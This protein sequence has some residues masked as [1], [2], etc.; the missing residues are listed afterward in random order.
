MAIK[1]QKFVIDEA[2]LDLIG[3]EFKFDHAKGLAEWIK[4]SCDAYLRESVPDDM[5][6]IILRLIEDKRGSINCIECIDFVGME[7]RQI[8]DAFKRFFDPLAAKKGAKEAQIKTLGGH[9][10]GGKFYM[11]Q[12]FK[13]SQAITYRNGK[14]NIFGFNSKRQYGFEEDYED[15]SM[16]AQE[17]MKKAKIDNILFP[18]DVKSKLISGEIGFTVVRG[19]NPHKV[20]GTASRDKLVEKLVYHPQARRLI[21]RKPISVVFND[22][23]QPSKL[24]PPKLIPKEGF[25]E[26]IVVPIPDTI[27]FEGK[28]IFFKMQNFDWPGRLVLRTSNDPLRGNLAT[29]NTIDFIG[30]VGVIASYRIFE[31]GAT[32]YSAQTEFLY[33]ECECPILEDPENDCVRNDRQKLIE[34]DRSLALIAWV[35]DRI[36]QLAESI[37]LKIAQE[38]KRQ[39]LRN[40]SV[41]NEILNRWKNRFMSQIWAEVF[42]GKGPAGANGSDIGAARG[43]KGKGGSVGGNEKAGAG[44]EGG[45]EKKHKPRFPSVLISGIDPDPLN[46]LSTEPFH[47]DTRHPAIY[48]RTKDVLAG[49]YWINTSRPLAEKIIKVYT[50]DSPRWREYLFQ[51]YVDIIIKE[52]IY[53]LGEEKTGLRP[54]DI[55]A[56]IDEI[57]TRIH[58]QAAKDLDAF[59]FEERFGAS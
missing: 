19:E 31:L 27:E 1:V 41:F 53:K 44:Q 55:D 20:R 46:P 39:D 14:L 51:R 16:S 56:K 13:T 15:R 45:S 30:E 28:P 7:K 36:E 23:I 9:G 33:G 3:N 10:N 54:E 38:R 47:C 18:V 59:L 43:G 25:E 2:V 24:V 26:S 17:A 34:N 22:E 57:T 42:M 5:Q 37:E 49:I 35:S 40:T 50:S 52:A 12:M 4:N 29:L 48:R 8:D 11:R 58:D 32:R 21:E 6:H